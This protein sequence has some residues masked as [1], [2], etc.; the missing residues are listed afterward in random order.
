MAILLSTKNKHSVI[1]KL[2]GSS[3]LD[4][5]ILK[6]IEILIHGGQITFVSNK[7]KDPDIKDSGN[8]SGIMI[9]QG[10]LTISTAMAILTN[11]IPKSTLDDVQAKLYAVITDVIDYCSE[12]EEI[13]T[14]EVVIKKSNKE[15]KVTQYTTKK[16][17]ISETSITKKKT[18]DKATKV[19]DKIEG[20]T[21][22]SVYTVIAAG[23]SVKVAVRITAKLVVS[24]RVVA[25]KKYDMLTSFGLSK[26]GYYESVHLEC[27]SLDKVIKLLGALIASI[28]TVE[29]NLNIMNVEDIMT[30]NN[31]E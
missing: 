30:E 20:V 10:D 18:L 6:D 26:S 16:P 17:T 11:K 23:V 7:E 24:I 28:A 22:D 3:V 9:G 19:G 5:L 15:E 31:I 8:N 25:N 2:F 29:S 1:R 13:Q 27:L 14:T 4:V 21:K 12:G